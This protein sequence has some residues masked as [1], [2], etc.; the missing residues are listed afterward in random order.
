MEADLGTHVERHLLIL[1]LSLKSRRDPHGLFHHN[2]DHDAEQR[3]I[4]CKL[5]ISNDKLKDVA[6]RSEKEKKNT[7]ATTCV[8][9]C[10]CVCVK[11]HDLT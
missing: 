10:A 11:I 6:R 5:L 8:C 4:H 2:D 9:V 7:R 1:S 3:M